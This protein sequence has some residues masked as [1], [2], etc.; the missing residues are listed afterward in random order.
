MKDESCFHKSVLFS[1]RRPG[2]DTLLRR[3]TL[4]GVNPALF[5]YRERT[6]SDPT[7]RPSGTCCTACAFNMLLRIADEEAREWA[8]LAAA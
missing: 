6:G 2:T 4:C 1:G 3:C 7:R 5:D 8:A